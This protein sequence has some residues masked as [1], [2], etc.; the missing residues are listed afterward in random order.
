ME[1][2]ALVCRIP[3]EV[4]NSVFLT[5]AQKILGKVKA[6]IIFFLFLKR[7]KL[8]FVTN[9]FHISQLIDKSLMA[10]VIQV[11]YRLEALLSYLKNVCWLF[12]HQ[13]K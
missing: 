8:Y 9:Y 10:S 4:N 6:L 1:F 3:H 13:G 7:R 5:P 2:W 11:K 12:V